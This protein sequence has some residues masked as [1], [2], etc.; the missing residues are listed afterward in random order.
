M[1]HSQHKLAD[2]RI[3]KIAGKS[4]QQIHDD[5]ITLVDER[6]ARSIDSMLADV[7]KA[8]KQAM[9]KSIGLVHRSDGWEFSE[10]NGRKSPARICAEAKFKDIIEQNASDWAQEAYNETLPGLKAAM[11]NSFKAEFKRAF[12]VCVAELAVES[13]RDIA[14]L[15]MAGVK[16]QADEVIKQV[17]PQDQLIPVDSKG[18]VDLI[19]EEAFASA[20][21]LKALAVLAQQIG[22]TDAPQ[23]D[24]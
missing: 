2:I 11:V 12:K 5:T 16:L 7:D 4:L 22:S 1:S 14:N 20:A 24:S 8:V 15:I 10:P 21:G 18:E 3:Q 9:V 6:I 13:A 23:L 19:N 17:I